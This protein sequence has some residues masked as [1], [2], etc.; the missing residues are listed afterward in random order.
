MTPAFLRLSPVFSLSVGFS[1][2]ALSTLCDALY[3]ITS[4]TPKNPFSTRKRQT[5][6]KVSQISVFRPWGYKEKSL[7]A[8]RT[9]LGIR[10]N[11]RS[12]ATLW[13]ILDFHR[14]VL[15]NLLTNMSVAAGSWQKLIALLC[16]HGSDQSC[17]RRRIRIPQLG[18]TSPSQFDDHQRFPT[19]SCF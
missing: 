4:R 13:K 17:W 15:A 11:F 19:S 10:S 18:T 16:G 3:L 6:P 7:K 12:W 1:A 5:G 9:T 14:Y 2:V 8:H